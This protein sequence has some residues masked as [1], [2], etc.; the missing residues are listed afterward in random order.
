MY[1]D[2]GG[3]GQ[4]RLERRD[5]A[6]VSA[7]V[8]TGLATAL[9]HTLD[10]GTSLQYDYGFVGDRVGWKVLRTELRSR[11]ADRGGGQS[12]VGAV[13]LTGVSGGVCAWGPQRLERGLRDA[14]RGK[15][16]SVGFSLRKDG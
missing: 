3:D 7:C 12:Q 2:H 14:A 10:R 9:V 15:Q 5:D 6:G 16:T 11:G 8:H 4:I 13:L 1:I